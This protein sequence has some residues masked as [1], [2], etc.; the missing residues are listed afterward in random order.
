M[1]FLDSLSRPPPPRLKPDL[2][3]W[4]DHTLAAAWIG[5]ATV[6]LR[7]GGLNILTDPVFSNRVGLGMGLFTLGPRR[8]ISPAL[9]IGE[10]PPLDLILISHAHFDHLDRPSLSRL[11]KTAQVITAAGT[12][13]LLDDLGFQRVTEL[14]WGESLQIGPL[15]VRAQEVRHW[16]ARTFF[17]TQ[18]GY[19]GYFLKS[20]DRRILFAGDTAYQE[21]FRS[22][23][24]VD[25][26]IFDIS[27]YDPYIQAHAN[28]EQTWAMAGHL[29][30]D[31]ILPVHHGTFNLSHE[32]MDE[33][34][35]RL[36]A[37]AGPRADRIVVRDIGGMWR[38]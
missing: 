30:A 17:D 31:F 37:A 10:L 1:R 9:A 14:R 36:L 3:H 34:L 28:P 38:A 6:L 35:A 22:C 21:F 23:G 13:D 7:I 27:A 5:H 29:P 18:R 8:K 20:A 26:A 16:G 2:S 33:P 4:N 15:E 12:R 32:P 11:A 19:N 25:L 24:P